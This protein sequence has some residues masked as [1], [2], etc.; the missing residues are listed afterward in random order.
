M[1]TKKRSSDTIAAL[2]GSAPALAPVP[3]GPADRP[4]TPPPAPEAAAELPAPNRLRPAA[5]LHPSQLPPVNDGEFDD[6][7]LESFDL[8]ADLPLVR[9]RRREQKDYQTVRI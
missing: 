8:P 9:P 5:A 1:S 6:T 7:D 4:A 2:L 3:D